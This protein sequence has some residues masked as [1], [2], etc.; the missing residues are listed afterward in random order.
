MSE[1]EGRL[2]DNKSDD[3]LLF[4]YTSLESA[5]KILC[6]NEIRLSSLPYTNDPLE[7][8]SP[9]IYNFTIWADKDEKEV[10][11]KLTQARQQRDNCVRIFCLC[12]DIPLQGEVKQSQKNADNTLFH[13]WARN[14]MWAQYANN[15]SGVCLV[16]D[17]DE[18]KNCFKKKEENDKNITV[19]NDRNIYYSNDLER[20]RSLMT[21]IN[22]YNDDISNFYLDENRQPCLFMKCE[23]F[24]D[25]MEHRFCLVNRN[26]TSPDTPMFINYGNSLKA[27][28]YGQ[29]LN[30]LIEIRIPENIEQYKIRWFLGIPQLF[31]K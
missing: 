5:C 25:E 15:H 26:L 18:L 22:A 4:H 3:S 12:R 23:D 14:R 6:S 9:S 7:F 27:I 8:I 17:K 1:L 10:I 29:R 11:E 21:D 31:K 13:G 30:D 16:F 2:L 28:I 19:I 24:Q 20:Y